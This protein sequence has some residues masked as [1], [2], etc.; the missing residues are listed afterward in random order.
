MITMF[1]KGLLNLNLLLLGTNHL[2]NGMQAG[3][4]VG[5]GRNGDVCRVK[6][7]LPMVMLRLMLIQLFWVRNR[8]MLM[9]QLVVY[10]ML[11]LQKWLIVMQ[12]R[13]TL[14]IR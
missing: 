6:L 5:S 10:K 11:M 1:R 4:F 13:M 9:M 3:A 12:Q 14:L 8:L 7:L 2:Q